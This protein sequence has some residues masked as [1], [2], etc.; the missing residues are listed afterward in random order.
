VETKF[1]VL[2]S[3]IEPGRAYTAFTQQIEMKRPWPTMTGRQQ[4]YID[5][6]WI[7]KF[8]EELPLHKDPIDDPD[9]PL[10]WNSPHGRWSVQSNWRD[11][12]HMLRLQRGLPY[13][14]ISP[15]EA[16]LRS[17]KDNHW[18]RVFNRYGSF[19]LRAKISPSEKPGRITMYHGW[20]KYLGFLHGGW[21]SVTSVKIKPTQ[22]VGG[23]GHL[24]FRPNYWG[25]AANN[26]DFK[27]QIEKYTG[28][29]AGDEPWMKKEV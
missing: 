28:P 4:F 18:V 10:H 25:P 1:H 29:L 24:E 6:P 22:L 21:Q 15:E 3:Q 9:F 13:V 12:R 2:N 20:E 17:I 19:V 14:H 7:L 11:H 23:Y 27:V 26:R 8:G 5:H 16:Q